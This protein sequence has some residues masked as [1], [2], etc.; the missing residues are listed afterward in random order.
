MVLT[1]RHFY[2]GATSL[3]L[4][5]VSSYSPFGSGVCLC[6]QDLNLISPSATRRDVWGDRDIY[7]MDVARSIFLL[8]MEKNLACDILKE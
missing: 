4:F 8:S 1:S 5:M 2:S 6:R 3:G 7:Y